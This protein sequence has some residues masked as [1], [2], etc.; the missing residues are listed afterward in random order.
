M[1][2]HRPRGFTLIELLV[3][4]AII[5]VLAAILLP[6]LFAARERANQTKC[7][8]NMRN[9]AIAL[10]EYADSNRGRFPGFA[11]TPIPGLEWANGRV[12]DGI[13]A[14]RID[15]HLGGAPEVWLCPAAP[16]IG[17]TFRS[18]AGTAEAGI[19]FGINNNLSQ[20]RSSDG[21][22]VGRPQSAIRSPRTTVLLVEGTSYDG[23]GELS[24]EP[25]PVKRHGDG[26]SW[27]NVVYCDTNAE[28]TQE[29]AY[30]EYWDLK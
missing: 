1:S 15:G 8:S 3:V 2:L 30:P 16:D 19:P 11:E 28:I 7:M 25:D 13:W 12:D 27:F 20:K 29:V 18:E 17:E 14:S 21:A 10:N 22:I 24:S 23:G 26:G 6:T 5:A 9:L 4:I